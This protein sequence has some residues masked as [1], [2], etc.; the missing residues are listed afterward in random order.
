MQSEEG[1]LTWIGNAVMAQIRGYQSSP[2]ECNSRQTMHLSRMFQEE[3]VGETPGPCPLSAAN[4]DNS[5]AGMG[6]GD[7]STKFA[8]MEHR[9][10]EHSETFECEKED[11]GGLDS[12][13]EFPEWDWTRSSTGFLLCESRFNFYS[14]RYLSKQKCQTCDLNRI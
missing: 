7:K 14:L 6:N 4:G 2:D 10:F 3:V 5:I 1:Q 12:H 13:L 9:H 11:C 8:F